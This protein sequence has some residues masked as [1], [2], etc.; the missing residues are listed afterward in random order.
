VDFKFVTCET[1]EISDD[2]AFTIRGDVVT[3]GHIIE[4]NQSLIEILQDNDDHKVVQR[5]GY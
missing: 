4:G 3:S 5:N 1:I 2:N